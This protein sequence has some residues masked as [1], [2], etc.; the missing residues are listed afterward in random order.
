[1]KKVYVITGGRGSG[2]STA[3]AT[4][5]PPSEIGKLCVFDCED[6]MSD[7]L[8]MGFTHIRLYD[9]LR[10]GGDMLD[11]LA[12]G[13]V[14]WVDPQGRGALIKY[15]KYFVDTL[16]DV[17]ESGEYKYFAIDTVEPIEAAMTAAVESGRR[18]FGWSGTRAY[19]RMETE[20]VRPLYNGLLE[21]VAQRGVEHIILTSH[22][23]GVWVD[24]RPVPGK[25][26]PGGRLQVLSRL[27]SIMFWL[28]AGDDPSGAPAALVLKARMGKTKAVGN[29]WDTKQVLPE[30]IPAFTWDAVEEYKRNPADLA[31]PAPGERMSETERE[32]VGELLT[33][34]QMELMVLGAEQR[35]AEAQ[36]RVMLSTSQVKEPATVDVISS[37]DNGIADAI[38]AGKSNAEIVKEL[39]VT[40]PAVLKVRKGLNE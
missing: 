8:H 39:D 27:S 22:L 3:V 38:T 25:V 9:E 2:K 14:P 31:N 30:R 29:K 19:G 20:G 5:P 6:S 35:A 12:K 26:K 11:R 1:M 37:V 15:Y 40:L 33:D 13:E 32:M 23:K 10:V 28:V 36:G 24:D 7:L 16:N 17:L 21:A 4:F 34:K 18:V